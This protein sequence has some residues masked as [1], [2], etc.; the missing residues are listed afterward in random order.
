M[1]VECDCLVVSRARD[2]LYTRVLV[3]SVECVESNNHVLAIVFTPGRG[4]CGV[5][6][7]ERRGV[8]SAVIDSHHCMEAQ[9]LGD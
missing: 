2:I 5:C 4:E 8:G 7:I 3:N 6:V 1:S 9:T